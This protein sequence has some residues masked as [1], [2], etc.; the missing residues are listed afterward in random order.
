MTRR[1]RRRAA[2][3]SSIPQ[4]P[5][6]KVTNSHGTLDVLRPEQV[7]QIH[8]A[9]LH[10]L[11]TSGIELWSADAR[12][13]FE[14]AGAIV[15]HETTV[16]RIGRDVIEHAL[17]QAPSSFTLTPRNPDRSVEFG[18]NNLVFGLVAGPPAVHDC[19][20][21]RRQSNMADYENFVRLGQYFNAI[22]MLGNQVSAPIELPANNRHLDC[23][24][25]NI[26]YSDLAYHC[27]AIGRG[28]ALDGVTMMAISRGLSVEEVAESPGVITVVNV[29]SPRR[30]DGEMAEGLMTMAEYGQPVSVTPFTLMGA[31]TPVTLAGA[32]V[33]ANAETL[34]GVA[35]TQLVRPGAPV[36]YGSFT[37]NVDMRSG[38]PAFGTPENAKANVAAGQLARR[39]GL[40]YR[41]SNCTAANTV[42]AQAA[43]EMQMAL[44]GAILGG[45]NI[46]YHAAGWMEGGLQASYEKLVLDV[47]ILQ[48]MMEFLTPVDTSDGDLALDAIARVPTG[49]HFFGDEHTMERY[50]TAFYQPM[51]SD[52]RTWEQW[53][54][55][56]ARTATERATGIWQRAL[57]EY[58]EPPLDSAIAEELESYIAHRKEEIGDGEP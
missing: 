45:A 33:Q 52:W 16:V 56:G 24:R 57:D 18:G 4:L 41:S 55:D 2:A 34:F 6:R 15:D 37:S 38:A 54:E 1:G 3:A 19:I 43:Y 8:E 44:W 5:W 35:L 50:D 48:H 53:N 49:G 9:S 21:G 40:P 13:L 17:A 51:L 10:V 14:E 27:T 29:N 26:T 36:V 39:Y 58:E 20:N 42:D 11:E 7:D 31:M 32:L 12:R 47:E 30:M 22:H 25:A 28:R 46:V 23:Y